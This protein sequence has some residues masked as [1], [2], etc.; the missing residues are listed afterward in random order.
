VSKRTEGADFV[1]VASTDAIVSGND[2]GEEHRDGYL[3]TAFIGQA[4]VKVRGPVCAG[5]LILPSGF[6]DGT[7]IAIEA[8]QLDLS[9]VDRVVGQAW[10]SNPGEDLVRVRSLV[11]L[12]QPRALSGAI[13]S[14]DDRLRRV[15]QL[16]GQE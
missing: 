8:G 13:H 6:E 11:G 1:L 15:E 7:G 12:V 4:M 3:L 9:L 5:D 10:E 2:P 14:L 16:L